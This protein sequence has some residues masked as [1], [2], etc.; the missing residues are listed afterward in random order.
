MSDDG[1]LGELALRQQQG[2]LV[3]DVIVAPRASRARIGPVTPARL[4]VAMPSR[5][6]RT[7]PCAEEAA[8]R[9][10]RAATITGAACP[11]LTVAT[12]AFRPRTC[13]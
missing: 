4:A 13:V 11:V 3:L 2:A 5:A 10:K 1:E 12:C 9:S 6:I 8:P 7:A